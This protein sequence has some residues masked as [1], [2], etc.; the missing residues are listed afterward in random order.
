MS[1]KSEITAMIFDKRGRV[2]SV[3]KNSYIKTHP[4]Q[5]KL[6]SKH[7]QPYKENL[8]AE[9]AAIIKCRNLEKAH[10]IKI[11]RFHSDGNPAL[12]KP[13]CIC[14]SAIKA[15]GIKNVIHT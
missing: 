13:C 6:A 1:R 12:A 9:I 14:E 2:L 11:F 7:G 4:L 8:H 10:T 3:A 5:K 15:A